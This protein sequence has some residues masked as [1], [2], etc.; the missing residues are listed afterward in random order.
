MLFDTFSDK[1]DRLAAQ[2]NSIDNMLNTIETYPILNDQVISVLQD[3]AQGYAQIEIGNFNADSG[4]VNV[5]AKAKDVEKINEYIKRLEEKEIFN[6]VKYS[7]YVM[8][9][10]GTWTINVI[11]TFAEGVGRGDK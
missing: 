3:T 2:S 1:R 6:S 5:S 7:G 11:C 4:I 10:D 9:Q 8:N